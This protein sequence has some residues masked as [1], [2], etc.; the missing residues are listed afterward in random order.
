VSKWSAEFATRLRQLVCA[1]VTGRVT[2]DAA[3]PR[4]V[5][6]ISDL[7]DERAVIVDEMRRRAK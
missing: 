6:L 4:L 3:E 1:E 7:E 5:Q 2:R